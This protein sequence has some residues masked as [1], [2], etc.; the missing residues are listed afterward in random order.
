MTQA[1]EAAGV[2]LLEDR[3]VELR[4]NGAPLWVVGVSDS[5]K[6]QPDVGRPS[7]G[8]PRRPRALVITHSPDAFPRL[9][10]Q[11]ALTLAGHTHGGQ[12]AIPGLRARFIPSRFGARYARGFVAER[13]RLLFVHPG[14]GT[15]RLTLRL[16]ARPE[17]TLLV[18]RAYA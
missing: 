10:D 4:F 16:G 8:C 18:L 14:I 7:P 17:V 9:P 5:H 11:A 12:I 2:T 6:R 3:S 13:G 15:S 1:L